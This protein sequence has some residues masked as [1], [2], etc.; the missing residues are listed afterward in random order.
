MRM[1]TLKRHIKSRTNIEPFQLYQIDEYF[2]AEENGIEI[3]RS[4]HQHLAYQ[5][6]KVI[7]AQRRNEKI[8]QRLQEI[9]VFKEQY[10]L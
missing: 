4:K 10:G 6:V 9:K 8:E 1:P 2:T 5:R 3:Y 7:L